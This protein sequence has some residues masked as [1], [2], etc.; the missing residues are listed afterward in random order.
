MNKLGYIFAGLAYVLLSL[1][2]VFR[3]AIR[4]GSFVY[5]IEHRHM[6]L[7]VSVLYMTL[8]YIY[9][10]DGVYHQF[11]D[12]FEEDKDE[13]KDEDKEKEKH[14]RMKY[15]KLLLGYILLVLLTIHIGK[16]YISM[17]KGGHH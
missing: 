13:D 17:E 4:I 11:E 1:A 3:G 6:Q 7:L 9:V 10:V 15:V 2:Y 16:K 14:K 5:Q 12:A 8:G